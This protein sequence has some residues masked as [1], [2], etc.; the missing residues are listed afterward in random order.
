MSDTPLGFITGKVTIEGLPAAP[1]NLSITISANPVGG[2]QGA[3]VPVQP[4]QKGTDY[5]IPLRPGNYTV[6]AQFGSAQ[7]PPENATVTSGKDTV[8]NFAF[9]K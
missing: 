6:L 2:G 4:N 5:A 9:G 3:T 8:V 7:S 1:T